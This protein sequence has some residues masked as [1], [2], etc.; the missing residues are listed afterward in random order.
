MALP[1]PLVRDSPAGNRSIHAFSEV[2]PAG[3]ADRRSLLWFALWT[4]S[5]HEAVVRQQLAGKGF[6]AFLPTITRWSRW[7][8]RRKRVD[9]PLFPGYCFV[10]MDPMNALPVLSCTGVVTLV[11][12]EG[13]PAPIPEREIESV[14]TLVESELR[15]DP[16]PLLQ[17]GDS[18]EV[19]RG[20]LRGIVGRLVRKGAHARLIL[21]V[22][23]I[24]QGVTVDVD[25]ADVRAY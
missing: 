8:D 25:A 19:V 4:R 5:R 21:S 10:R 2:G 23:L 24:G 1:S 6:D 18:V 17:E 22:G 16:C 14:R 7:K 13:R 12:F 9:W 3:D 11:S 20:P 15:F